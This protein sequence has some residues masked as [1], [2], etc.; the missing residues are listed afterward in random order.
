M[1]DH[2]VLVSAVD[3]PSPGANQ[4]VTVVGE[5]L[6]VFEDIT[7]LG[8]RQSLASGYDARDRNRVGGV[9]LALR[10]APLSLPVGQE[11]GYLP[12]VLARLAAEAVP[13]RLRSSPRPRCRSHDSG[14]GSAPTSATKCRLARR[15]EFPRIDHP[16]EHIEHRGCKRPPVRVDTDRHIHAGLPSPADLR[17]DQREDSQALSESAFY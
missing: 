17:C 10:R 13:A 16:P 8:R 2:E 3:E 6:Q 4:L 11:G 15:G 12:D 9:G 5:H 14:P 7:A 1:G